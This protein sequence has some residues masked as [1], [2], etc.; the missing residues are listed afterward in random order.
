[1]KLQD[2]HGQALSTAIASSAAAYDA[3]LDLFNSWRMDPLALLAPVL[4]TIPERERIVY[5][6]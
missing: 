5:V 1:M 2:R 3:A 6:F 4:A